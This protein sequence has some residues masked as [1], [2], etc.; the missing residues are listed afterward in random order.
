MAGI[1]DVTATGSVRYF[2]LPHLAGGV[3]PPSNILCEPGVTRRGQANS[4]S[5][6]P[7]MPPGEQEAIASL[8][9]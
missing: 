4:K 7:E 6:P 1:I 9:S 3:E 5:K 8:S 2:A